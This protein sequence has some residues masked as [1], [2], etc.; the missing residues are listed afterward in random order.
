M[1]V[2]AQQKRCCVSGSGGSHVDEFAFQRGRIPEESG[3]RSTTRG[4]YA[5]ALILPLIIDPIRSA[6]RERRWANPHGG[7]QR[8]PITSGLSITF[9]PYG[10]QARGGLISTAE[11]GTR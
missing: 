9:L 3:V 1:R 8:L 6:S 4:S 2:E 11:L 5:N 7:V 10:Y